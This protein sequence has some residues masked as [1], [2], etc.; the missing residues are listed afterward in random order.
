[1]TLAPS[2]NIHAPPTMPV[3]SLSK[4]RPDPPLPPSGG[5]GLIYEQMSQNIPKC[6]TIL[7]AHS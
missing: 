4:G 1:M 2:P 6:P 5:A 3:L 7:P